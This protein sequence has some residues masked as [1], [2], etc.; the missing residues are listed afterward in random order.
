MDIWKLKSAI[1]EI[2]I[3]PDVVNSKIKVTQEWI[4]ELEHK[5]MKIIHSEKEREKKHCLRDL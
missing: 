5:K 3:L 2:Q 4:C 1:F